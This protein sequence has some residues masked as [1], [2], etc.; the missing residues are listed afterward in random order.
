ME[1][2]P[3]FH[4]NSTVWH[5]D[6][7]IAPYLDI[8]KDHLVKHGYAVGAVGTYVGCVIHFARWLSRSGL[9]IDRIDEA[10]VHRFLN[11]HLPNCHCAKPV[12]R[13]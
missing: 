3:E 10:V 8:F 12:C 13:G 5:V 11:V 6:S 4:R 2:T 9:D 7:R 1:T